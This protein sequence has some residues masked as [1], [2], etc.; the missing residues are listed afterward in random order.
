[1]L[2]GGRK[3]PRDIARYLQSRGAHA[4][5]IKL[6]ADGAY[7]LSEEGEEIWAP[8]LEV[9]VVDALGAGDAWAA[10]F[11]AGVARD[12]P[13]ETCVRLGNGVGACCVTAL[14]ATTGIRSMA[15]TT[16]MMEATPAGGSG[17]AG[18]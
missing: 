15:E 17:G 10:G 2:A 5:G 18:A 6:G 12:L 13:L 16:A 8:A 14:G 11:L 4:V 9:P 7:F 3:H 1:M